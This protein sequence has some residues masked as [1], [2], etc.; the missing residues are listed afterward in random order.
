VT[1]ARK[2]RGRIAGAL[3]NFVK[4]TFAHLVA[5]IVRFTRAADSAGS[6]RKSQAAARATDRVAMRLKSAG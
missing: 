6:C 5:L 2:T 1:N 3:L 4:A